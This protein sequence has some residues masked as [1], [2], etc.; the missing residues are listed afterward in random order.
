[1]WNKVDFDGLVKEAERSDRSLQPRTKFV[2][3]DKSYT[4]TLFTRLMLQGKVK[5]AVRWLSDNTRRKVLCPDD[6]VPVK[7]SD[8]FTVYSSVT[9]VTSQTPCSSDPTPLGSFV[10]PGFEDVEVTGNVI[11]RAASAIQGSAGL[12]AVIH[13]LLRY[14]AHSSCLRDQVASLASNSIIPWSDI[15]GFVASRLIAWIRIP[16]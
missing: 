1:M 10:L 4:V 8:G 9:D 3:Q 13:A 14:H 2:D 5:A 12:V 11:Q 16:V 6:K 15:R 7:F